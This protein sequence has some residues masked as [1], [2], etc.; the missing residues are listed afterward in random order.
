MKGYKMK[1]YKVKTKEDR[2]QEIKDLQTNIEMGVKEFFTSEKY[3][4]YLKFFSKF[5]KY[6]SNN[7][8]SI[9]YQFPT[10]TRVGSYQAWK[11]L[12]RVVKK[13]EKGIKILVPAEYTFFYDED[14]R[15]TLISEATPEQKKEIELKIIKTYKRT[16][17]KI[18]NVFDVSQT[19]GEELPT[20]CEALKGN[21][22]EANTIFETLKQII[23]IP[24]DVEN[25]KSGA[26][27][28]YNSLENRIALNID[29]SINQ[30]TKTLVYEYTHSILHHQ[31]HQTDRETAEVEAESVAYIVCN[32]FN[33][34]TS[35]YSFGYITSWSSSKELKELKES[36][37]RI[38]I[39]ANQIIEKIESKLEIKL[40]S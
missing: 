5:Y 19:D 23:E 17:F 25:I 11:A 14:N 32:Y 40:A 34:D 27:G 22:E 15:F 9:L 37:D 12:N 29:N 36:A 16:T 33:F 18:G 20:I 21:N 24:V 6:S 8:M 13:G 1:N 7:I 26:Y 28:Y 10:A 3:E 39:T 38:H 30:N 35:D 31:D 4:Q 2:E